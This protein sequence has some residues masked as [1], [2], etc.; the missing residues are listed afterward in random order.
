VRRPND[1]AALPL[2]V[3]MTLRLVVLAFAVFVV[4]PAVAQPAPAPGRIPT[5]TRLVKLFTG[6]EMDLVAATHATDV[7]ALDAVLDPS[8]EMRTG[9]AP[10]T[11]V[12]RD[13]WI[14]DAR[15][16]AARESSRIDQMAVHDFGDVVIVSF[17]AS[18][19]AGASHVPPA[20]LVVDWWKRDGETW[21][22]AVRYVSDAPARPASRPRAPGT[23]DKRY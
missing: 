1:L 2:E 21:K 8:F 13:A 6:R 16:A 23:I 10:G 15:R 17:R 7:S 12:P 18:A 19:V 14:R 4:A 22:L 9:E 20:R 5:V 3:R 11:P